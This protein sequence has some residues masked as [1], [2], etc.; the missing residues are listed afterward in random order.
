MYAIEFETDVTSPFIRL[1]DY[2]KLKNQHVKVIVLSESLSDE[3]PA[4]SVH[5]SKYNFDDLVG[6]LTWQGDALKVQQRLRDEW[7]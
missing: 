6:R 1:H 7:V 4:P 3:V 5:Q 2:E